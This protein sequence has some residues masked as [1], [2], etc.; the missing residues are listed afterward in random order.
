MLVIRRACS[1]APAAHGI[2]ASRQRSCAS[3]NELDGG[4]TVVC[5][6]CLCV[7][8]NGLPL[9]GIGPLALIHRS[10][11]LESGEY[12]TALLLGKAGARVEANS[13]GPQLAG[14]GPMPSALIVRSRSSSRQEAKLATAVVSIVSANHAI[15]VHL[16][17]LQISSSR[18]GW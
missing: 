4:A 8:P 17:A 9:E 12:G 11:A 16:D 1:L 13:C 3:H 5:G 18:Q 10:T 2:A 6:R 15:S 14:T 7:D